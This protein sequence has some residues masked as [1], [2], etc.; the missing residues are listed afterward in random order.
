M[1]SRPHRL[2]A[3]VVQRWLFVVTILAMAMRLVAAYSLSKWVPRPGCHKL[4]FKRTI[5][6]NGCKP[7]DVHLNG[8]RGH[9]PSWTVPPSVKQADAEQT[10]DNKFVTYATCCRMTEHELVR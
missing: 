6:I 10:T 2:S 1:S 9:C 4:A 3:A 7:F 8:C 5:K